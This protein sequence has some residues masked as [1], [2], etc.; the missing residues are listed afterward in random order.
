MKFFKDEFD[1][2]VDD[3]D[4]NA[5]NFSLGIERTKT[6]SKVLPGGLKGLEDITLTRNTFSESSPIPILSAS[7]WRN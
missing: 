2:T 7:N 5:V 3:V 6:D 1:G 4:G